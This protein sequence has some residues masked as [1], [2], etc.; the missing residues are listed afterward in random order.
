MSAS[1]GA[2]AEDVFEGWEALWLAGA[3]WAEGVPCGN[4]MAGIMHEAISTQ[5]AISDTIR[6]VHF[7][8]MF[9]TLAAESAVRAKPFSPSL[10]VSLPNKALTQ[11]AERRWKTANVHADLNVNVVLRILQDLYLDVVLLALEL[12]LVPVRAGHFNENLLARHR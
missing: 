7:R 12:D 10:V 11:W 5:S 3:V 6:I 2:P 4:A 1:D 8:L 9:F